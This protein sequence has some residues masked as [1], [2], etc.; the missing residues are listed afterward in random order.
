[1]LT[2]IDDATGGR[3]GETTSIGDE[4]RGDGG[5]KR[6]KERVRARVVRWS[7]RARWVRLTD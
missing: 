5:E 3:G 1:M 4:G 2:R 7:S 6:Q